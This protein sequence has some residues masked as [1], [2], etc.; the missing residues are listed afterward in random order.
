MATHTHLH[1]LT[2]TNTHTNTH[3]Y[4]HW[5]THIHALKHTLTHTHTHLSK[6]KFQICLYI[7]VFFKSSSAIKKTSNIFV[8]GLLCLLFWSVN[9]I[10]WAFVE[11]ALIFG[12][13]KKEKKKFLKQKKYQLTPSVRSRKQMSLRWNAI[14]RMRSGVFLKI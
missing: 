6:E 10:M 14:G 7:W 5:H 11:L 2:H 12:F 4:T 9:L 3:T 1:A 8:Y 13:S